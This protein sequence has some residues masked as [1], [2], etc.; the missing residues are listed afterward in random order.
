MDSKYLDVLNKQKDN[1]TRTISEIKQSIAD[2]K[3]IVDSH[4]ISLVSSFKSRNAEFRSLPP[5]LTFVLPS[6]TPQHIK[7]EQLY[8][9]FGSL[10]APSIKTEEQVYTLDSPGAERSWI[11]KDIKTTYDYYERLHSVSCL[12]EEEVWTSGTDAIMRLY[13]LQGQLVKSILTKSGNGPN[14]IA[15]TRSGNLVYIDSIDRTLNIVKQEEIQ[16]V[17]ELRGWRPLNV[18]SISNDELLVVM[19]SDDDK[20]TKVVRYSG[21]TEKQSIQYNDKGQSL[22]S[23][24]DIKFISE[25]NNLDICVSDNKA[26]AVVVVNQAGKLRFTYT[27]PPSTSEVSFKPYG[28]T[29]DSQSQ[30]LSADQ[31]NN[32][33]H[34]LDQDGQFLRYID[35]LYLYYPWGLCVDIN[36]DIFVAECYRGHVKKIKYNM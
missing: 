21:T 31:Y 23:S 2:L 28:I 14:D 9:Q 18:C 20:Q 13:N 34:I 27:G 35:N 22:Y 25:N 33:I 7:K 4:D 16:T 30:I 15:V 1:I 3:Q 17:I 32:R 5:K 10:S 11:I 12:S 19:L 6:F 24:G 8:Q 26:H 29:T 36:D